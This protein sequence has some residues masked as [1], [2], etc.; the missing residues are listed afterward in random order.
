[1]KSGTSG[2]SAFH[3]REL[4]VNS[5][6]SHQASVRGDKEY[7]RTVEGCSLSFSA[8]HRL[9][10]QISNWLI[11][12]GLGPGSH[13]AVFMENEVECLL[14]H[15]A[16]T[17]MGAVSIPINASAGGGMLAHYLNFSDSVAVI[18]TPEFAQRVVA[19]GAEV[20]P[21]HTLI[22]VGQ[23]ERTAVGRF[24]VLSFADYQGA[25]DAPITESPNFSDLAFIMFTSGTTGPSKGVMFP[26]A[27]AFLWDEG[28]VPMF[29]VGE[30]DRYFV[31]TPLSH[32]TGLFSGAWMMMV[33]G[34][35]VGLTR[36]FSAS[37]FW[38][39]VRATGATYTTL[40]GAMVS[41]LEGVPERP[42]D[43]N[44]PMRFIS[45]APYP[46][47]WESFER[48]FGAKLSIA[49][50]L[51]DHSVPTRLPMDPPAAKRG[52]TGHVIEGFELLVV[53]EDDIPVPA[54][55]I[56][57]V[58][59]R[60]RLPWHC[61]LGYYKQPEQTLASRLHEWFHTG[62]RGYLDEDGYFWFVD[63]AKDAIRR[64]GENIS[65]YEVEQYAGRH[66][67]V[68]H[69]AAYPLAADKSEQEVAVSVVLKADTTFH[70]RELIRFCLQTMPKFMVPRFVHVAK[71][72][73]RNLNQRVE[74]YKLREWAEQNRGS[75]WDRESEAEFRRA[76][77]A[78]KKT[79]SHR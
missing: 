29:G 69:I 65:S 36:R 35:S 18:A 38:D 48:R 3:I 78:G 16:I 14:S 4:T 9:T 60:S 66:P 8:V 64:L 72:L 40:L 33:V 49:Y 67:A 44:H 13:I 17:K 39:Q 79:T 56:G 34:G 7:I 76:S 21:L 53:D 42:D 12:Q 11:A 10:N 1:V 24:R 31:C 70:P 22:V 74:K 68:M 51:S 2:P 37:Q 77:A 27:R 30:R 59:I 23:F 45:A 20:A 6:L 61:S 19:L 5:V 62:D 47:T 71:D 26:Q 46:P 73:P 50:G 75:L 63:R 52:S 58:L 57:E 54:R 43:A 55:T 41:F 28:V 15:I 25:P 32:A